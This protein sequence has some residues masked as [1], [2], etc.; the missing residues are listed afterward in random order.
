MG[1]KNYKV[2]YRKTSVKK[3]TRTVKVK[4]KSTVN[5]GR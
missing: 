3:K 4:G 2:M 1:R 5:G